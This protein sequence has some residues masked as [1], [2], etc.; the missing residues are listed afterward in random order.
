L[1]KPLL[2]FLSISLPA[3]ALCL[4]RHDSC[5]F[6]LN[7]AKLLK[8]AKKFVQADKNFK[9]AIEFDTTNIDARIEYANLLIDERKYVYA[10]DQFKKVLQN[11]A[12]HTVALQKITEV[13]FLLRM[14][15]CWLP[16]AK[17]EG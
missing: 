9:K 14:E 5:L 7:Q 17:E 8:E 12:R 11:N 16:P 3:A 13:S 10:V 15:R 2:I 6:Y 4:P 1:K